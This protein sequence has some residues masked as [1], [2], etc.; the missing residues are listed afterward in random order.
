MSIRPQLAGLTCAILL[1]GG[2][3]ARAQPP[4]GQ[5]TLQRAPKRAQVSVGHLTL[6]APTE[7]QAVLTSL[8]EEVRQ[9][10]PRLEDD[11][12]TTTRGPYTLFLLPPGRQADDEL[13][14]LDRMAPPEAAGFVFAE[15]RVGAIRLG[16]VETYPY[17]G[18]AMVLAHE[19]THMMVFDATGG[20]VPRWFNEGV[21]TSE[22]RR[23]GLRDFVVESSTVMFGEV[24]RLDELDRHFFAPGNYARR[25]YALSFDF[26]SWSSREYGPDFVSRVLAETASHGFEQAW[27]NIA[28]VA[29]GDSESRW[30][31]RTLFFH[32]WLPA[33][34]S[35]GFLW[36]LLTGLALVAG[37]RKRRRIREQYER[38]ELEDSIREAQRL[39]EDRP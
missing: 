25:A 1:V 2:L 4:E 38:W 28:G 3:A 35:S 39:G 22:G 6:E 18:L 8:A 32:R 13:R 14:Y 24:P 10:V 36:S 33:L 21:A 26:V 34:T 30:R 20:D 17:D 37:V 5:S 11:L 31:R 29:L 19:I 7:Y 23:R 15:S 16:K 9:I 12:G 27:A